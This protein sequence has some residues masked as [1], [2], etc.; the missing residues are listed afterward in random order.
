MALSALFTRMIPI[1]YAAVLLATIVAIGLGFLW[2]GPLFGKQ[3]RTLSG[4]TD[5]KMAAATSKGMGATYAIMAASTLVM[6]YVLAHSLVFASTYLNANGFTAGLTA[7]FWNWLGFVM[8]VSL[9]S[10]L[11]DGK[12]WM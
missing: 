11:W 6:Y 7:A 9:G 10:V 12:T 1:N 4:W 5:E 2:Y 3:W 8:P